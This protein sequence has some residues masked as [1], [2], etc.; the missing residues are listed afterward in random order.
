M[1]INVT[2]EQWSDLV[3]MFLLDTLKKRKIRESTS[4][5]CQQFMKQIGS[6]MRPHL[7]RHFLNADVEERV[8]YRLIRSTFAKG[9]RA[10]IDIGASKDKV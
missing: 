5:E 7:I 1:K 3:L 2:T 8:K 4:E 10:T 6:P 9:S